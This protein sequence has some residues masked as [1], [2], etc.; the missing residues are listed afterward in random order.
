MASPRTFIFLCGLMAANL[1]GA[2]FS[3]PAVLSL[4]PEVIKEKLA[5]KLKNRDAVNTL[6]QLPLLSTIH[7]EPASGI[8][9]RLVKSVLKH[10]TQLNITSASILQLQ[11]QPGAKDQELI[12][13]VPLDLVAAF[14]MPLLKSF[15]EMHMQLEVETIIQ[16]ET[17][18]AGHSHLVLS[19]CSDIRRSLHINLL[20]KYSFQVN[21]LANKFIN[22]LAPALPKLVKSELCP[23][24]KAAFEDMR[25][26]F[27]NL[28]R[29]SIS[30]NSN[31]LEF[32]LLSSAI[33]SNAVHLILG[34]KLLNS[35]GKVTKWFNV[36][37]VSLRMPTLYNV[38][39]SLT[40]RKDVVK[41][42][43]AAL[44]P[45]EEF[46]VLLESVL[47]DLD[48]LL[49]S[50]IKVI[51]EK[52]ADQLGPKQTV[53]ILIQ[54][55]LDLLLDQNIAR[56]AQ[57]IVLLIFTT[58]EAKRPLLT[59]GIEATSEAQFYME[60]H[61][62][63]LSFNKIRSDRIHLLNSGIG[64]FK[65]DILKNI[66]TKILMSVLLPHENG[67]LRSGIPLSMVK[68]LGFKEASSSVTKDALVITPT[69]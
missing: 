53:K 65:P 57:E 35:E 6:Q 51:S 2:N 44:L 45:P 19:N 62:L 55:T 24:V 15:M 47:P 33:F 59:L 21:S 43:V 22:L 30:L 5:E 32:D 8:I 14:N 7:N 29:V 20:K 31:H 9:S 40:M 69:S 18:K 52:A 42:A 38:P 26:D 56:V 23:V 48:H 68:A 50:S 34:A 67:K 41:A 64:L 54:G 1:V 28:V 10:I 12:V 58:S 61:R 27:L 3:P 4:S 16:V 39:F 60:G 25:V 11:V 63:M 17:S 49:K 46:M 13:K 36:S 37:L 66:I